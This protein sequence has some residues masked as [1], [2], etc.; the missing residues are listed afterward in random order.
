MGRMTG[1]GERRMLWCD[2]K[3]MCARRREGK[4]F[5]VGR[6]PTDH[7]LCCFPECSRL[8]QSRASY[9][10]IISGQHT[11]LPLNCSHSLIHDSPSPYRGVHERVQFSF[12][13]PRQVSQP[14]DDLSAV[15]YFPQAH[16]PHTIAHFAASSANKALAPAPT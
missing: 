15:L 14:L 7:L 2:D 11:T 8:P 16:R 3:R 12:A 5:L 10:L 9:A 13:P 4:G 6:E 1:D